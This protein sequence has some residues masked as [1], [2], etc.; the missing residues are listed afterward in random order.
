M[1]QRSHVAGGVPVVLGEGSPRKQLG[2][3]GDSPGDIWTTDLEETDRRVEL[4]PL[5]ISH[6]E[7]GMVEVEERV[8]VVTETRQ[9]VLKTSG[10]ATQIRIESIES[11]IRTLGMAYLLGLGT[12]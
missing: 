4:L 3:R 8:C 7:I 9:L 1:V 6:V 12:H 2:Y 10:L 11:T 5:P